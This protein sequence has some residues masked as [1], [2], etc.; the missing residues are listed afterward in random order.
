MD[1]NTTA[2]TVI[3]LTIKQKIV[4]TVAVEVSA[5]NIVTK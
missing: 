3:I 2:I 1:P 4:R 5:S